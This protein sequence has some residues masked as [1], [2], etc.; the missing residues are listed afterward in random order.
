MNTIGEAISRV[1]NIIKAVTMDSFVTDRVIYSLIQKYAK[2]YIKRQDAITTRAKFGSLFKRLPCI[3]L[4]EVDKV[5]ACCDVK[6]GCTIMRTQDKLPGIM[7][8]PQGPLLRS[9]SSV[10]SS[11][12]VYRTT[13]SLYT[14][15]TKTSAF[16]Y[17]KNKYYW[18]MNG[19]IYIPNVEW[20]SISIEGIFD[21]DLVGYTCDDPCTQ[22]QDQSINIPPELFAEIEQQVINDFMKS[23]QIPQDSFISDKQNI[24]R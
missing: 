20:D 18:F 2:M 3:P 9:V 16:K 1:R 13:P 4:V 10:D 22:V 11:I 14:G 21:T 5:E 12:E 19:Y 7:E 23:A 17:N 6:S 15:M 24:L 8:G